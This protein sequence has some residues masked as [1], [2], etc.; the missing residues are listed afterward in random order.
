MEQQATFSLLNQNVDLLKKDIQNIIDNIKLEKDHEKKIKLQERKSVYLEELDTTLS[1]IK[2]IQKEEKQKLNREN[3]IKK[4]IRTNDSIKYHSFKNKSNSVQ[5]M[6]EQKDN[7]EKAKEIFEKNSK[8]K[9]DY[10]ILENSFKCEE[11]PAF[12][13][14]SKDIIDKYKLC[15]FIELNES[16]LENRKKWLSETFDKGKLYF[17]MYNKLINKETFFLLLSSK[18]HIEKYFEYIH[19]YFD[20]TN[21]KNLEK[22]HEYL[23]EYKAATVKTKKLKEKFN[24]I[25]N[26]TSI[27]VKNTNFKINEF[28]S[29]YYDVVIPINN[30]IEKKENIINEKMLLGITRLYDEH[31]DEHLEEYL[32]VKNDIDNANKYIFNTINNLNQELY[33]YLY[34]L[35][36]KKAIDKKNK[37]QG[38]YFKKWSGMSK[39]EKIN[40]FESYAEY[41]PRKYL[42]EPGIITDED[43]III[44]INE[45]KQLIT[46]DDGFDRIKYKN[47]QWNINAGIIENIN[48][49]KY[50]E[51]K[52][53]FFLT[54]EKE[55]VK[56]TNTMEPKKAS[57]IR[58]VLNKDTNKII[59][60]ELMKHLIVAKKHKKLKE[61]YIK[62]LKDK[63]LEKI[64]DKLKLKRIMIN[65][66]TEINKKF[67]EIYN[68]IFHAD[69]SSN[70]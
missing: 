64:K 30:L 9:N 21:K 60:E 46:L 51:T 43:Q 17:Q 50:D 58:T 1:Q 57:S 59:N 15:P 16:T 65:D 22:I 63:F 3:E 42:L 10:N 25:I 49:L 62:D 52:H 18:E 19:S 2:Q 39:E 31:Y 34:N 4:I 23:K 12:L 6:Q 24:I 67:D 8:L 29:L 47:L 36:I 40:R 70:S 5:L 11:Y 69:N 45:L 44:L 53:T 20:D 56:N 41:F 13:F 35:D 33:D 61:E 27:I 48:C 37:Q 28:L 68:I 66:R 7:R 54:I 32:N 38:K 14:F 55:I 26:N